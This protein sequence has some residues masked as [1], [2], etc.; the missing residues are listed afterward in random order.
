MITLLI[1]DLPQ[2]EKNQTGLT[3][4]YKT[5]MVAYMLCNNNNCY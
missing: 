3:G 2:E 5:K 4:A 1:Q